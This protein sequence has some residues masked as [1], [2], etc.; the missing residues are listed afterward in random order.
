EKHTKETKRWGDE[1]VI[2][3]SYQLTNNKDSM[4]LKVELS[5]GEK[6]VKDVKF[7]F[8]VKDNSGK[9]IAGLNNLNVEGATKLH[10]KPKENKVLL[11]NMPNIFGNGTYQ[12]TTTVNRSGG[13]VI[14]DQWENMT[15]FTNTKDQVFY[16]VVCPAK[17][18]IVKK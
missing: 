10:F 6:Q 3:N 18:T 14:C 12:I 17:L 15:E 1:S 16:P 11:I 7:G 4:K 9:V 8:R 13:S 2:V 5:A